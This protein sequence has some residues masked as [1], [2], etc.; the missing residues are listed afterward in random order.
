MMQ[1]PDVL[2]AM[3][4]VEAARF[5]VGARRADLLPRLSLQGAIG[6]Q[7]TDSSEWFD[8]DQW[9]R[10]LTANLLGPVF[11]GS[12]LRKNI[13]LAEARLNEAAARLWTFRGHRGQ[14]GRDRPPGAGSQPRA[15]CAAGV[16]FR[17]N[18]G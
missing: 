6:L 1:R 7:S 4:R 12:R 13:A 15:S 8:P 11:Q 2:A 17:R 3:Q 18:P 14:R 16:P 9:F 10:N 5:S